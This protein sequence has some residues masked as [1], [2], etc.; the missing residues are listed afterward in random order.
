MILFEFMDPV[1][2]EAMAFSGGYK[3]MNFW[4]IQD[5]SGVGGSY[6]HFFPGPN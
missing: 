2:S 3:S 1:I 6:T 4:G 5:G